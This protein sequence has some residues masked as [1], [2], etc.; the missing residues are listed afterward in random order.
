MKSK[1]VLVDVTLPG[2]Y[3]C[4]QSDTNKTKFFK[5]YLEYGTQG[6]GLSV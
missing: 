2:D 3:T 4:R 6:L 5:K 1:I